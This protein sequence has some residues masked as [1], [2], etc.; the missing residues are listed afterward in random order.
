MEAHLSVYAALARVAEVE[1]QRDKFADDAA[2][3]HNLRRQ[4]NGS[5]TTKSADDQTLYNLRFRWKDATSHL[6]D[7]ALRDLYADFSLSEDF[8]DNDERFPLW[9]GWTK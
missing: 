5:L 8:G 9:L 6:G 7:E 1:S 4:K 2:P 3:T